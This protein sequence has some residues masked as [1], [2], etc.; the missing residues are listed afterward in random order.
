[1]AK[2]TPRERAASQLILREMSK[3]VL[4]WRPWRKREVIALLAE[5]HRV[6]LGEQ[7]P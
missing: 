7:S 5:I 1:V 6:V 4:R 2:M 3:A